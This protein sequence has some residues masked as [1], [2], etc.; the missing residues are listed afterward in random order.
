MLYNFVTVLQIVDT[1]KSL[2]GHALY[3]FVLKRT[4]TGEVKTV[5]ECVGLEEDDVVTQED[6]NTYWEEID[7]LD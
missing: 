7:G 2:D 3:N 1:G 5:Y 6:F 4:D